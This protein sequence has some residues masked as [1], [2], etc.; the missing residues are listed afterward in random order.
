ML[1]VAG[2]VAGVSALALARGSDRVLRLG[3]FSLL[4]VSLPGW[5]LMRAGAEW[6]YSKEGFS[7]SDDPAWLVVGYVTAE[8]GGVL[9]LVSLIVGGV[10]VRRLRAGRGGTLLRVSMALAALV[11]AA[12][13]VAVWAMGAKPD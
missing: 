10:G 6:I 12:Y 8:G 1:L 13:V 7:G 9:L 4:A 5:I 11:I 3:Y 2:L